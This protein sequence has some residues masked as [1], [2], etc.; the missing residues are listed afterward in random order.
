MKPNFIKIDTFVKEVQEKIQLD[1]IIDGH[2]FGFGL[3]GYRDR[4]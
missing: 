2:A 4:T 3:E 1:E